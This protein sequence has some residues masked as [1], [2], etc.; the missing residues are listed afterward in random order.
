MAAFV[1]GVIHAACACLRYKSVFTPYAHAVSV[2]HRHPKAHI[3][4]QI[5]RLEGYRIVEVDTRTLVCEVLI[6]N[7]YNTLAANHKS[8]CS[9]I[10]R[11]IYMKLFKMNCNLSYYTL[12]IL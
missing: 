6:R 1:P 4:A 11:C 3:G 8:P 10:I 9:R 7:V 12:L 2:I 5:L